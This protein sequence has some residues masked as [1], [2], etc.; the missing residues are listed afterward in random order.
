M[1]IINTMIYMLVVLLG[2]FIGSMA[3]VGVICI[4]NMD[5]PREEFKCDL[6]GLDPNAIIIYCPEDR[7]VKCTYTQ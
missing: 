6:E 3:A 1:R 5:P 7:R 2:A 4:T